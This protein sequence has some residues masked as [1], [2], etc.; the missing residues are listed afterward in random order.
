MCIKHQTHCSVESVTERGA[1]TPS[2]SSMCGTGRRVVEDEQRTHGVQ[3]VEV[4]TPNATRRVT[5]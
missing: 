2:L 5:E 4:P 1:E 3:G